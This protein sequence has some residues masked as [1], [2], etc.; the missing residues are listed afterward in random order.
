MIFRLTLLPVLLVMSS[1][2]E[3]FLK[4]DVKKKTHPPLTIGWIGPL[5]GPVSLLGIDNLNTIKMALEKINQ[6]KILPAPLK[7]IAKDD[8]YDT[9]LSISLYK[10][11]VSEHK[12]QIIFT[13]TYTATFQ[14]ADLALRDKIILINSIDND[15]NL[16]RLNRNVF[17]IAKKTSHLASAITGHI[18]REKK[19]MTS[20]LYLK[21]DDFMP[22]VADLIT[23]QLEKSGGK[24]TLYSYSFNTKDFKSDFLKMKSQGSDSFVLLGYRELG[25]AMRDAREAGISQ[26][27]YTANLMM[28]DDAKEAIEHTKFF[29]FTSLDGN[30]ERCQRFLVDYEKKF[31]KKPL[32]EWTA[33][34]AWDSVHILANALNKSL[35]IE[36]LLIDNIR[37]NLASTKDYEGLSGK[38]SLNSDGSSDGIIPGL[39]EFVGGRSR[40]VMEPDS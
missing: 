13:S 6:E 34:Q 15:E 25:K 20:V 29:D 5:S 14:L 21:E 38:I 35:N 2:C 3:W 19:S 10:K 40:K 7:L 4:S 8:E 32:L 1:A 36:G 22:I 17:L 18:K 23:T 30:I 12:P 33:F 39:Y 26:P 28:K 9:N 31:G 37:T 16:A 11:L 24:V 27:F